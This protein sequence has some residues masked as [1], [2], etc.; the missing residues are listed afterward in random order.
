MSGKLKDPN[1]LP[2]WRNCASTHCERREECTGPSECFVQTTGRRA[3]LPAFHSYLE[4]EYGGALPP[5]R[6][7]ERHGGLPY[8]T[9]DAQRFRDFMAGFDA[10]RSALNQGN[11][12]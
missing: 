7:D 12:K 5:L 6:W 2:N 4:T 10:G 11:G 3:L 8:Y 1:T 9:A